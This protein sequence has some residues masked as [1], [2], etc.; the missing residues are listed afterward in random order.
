[1]KLDNIMINKMKQS[2][3]QKA[4]RAVKLVRTK[5]RNE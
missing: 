4:L 3:H 2:K 5:S 1:M